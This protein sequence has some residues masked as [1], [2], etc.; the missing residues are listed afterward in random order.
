[1]DLMQVMGMDFQSVVDWLVAH[2][3]M[4]DAD[5]YDY[6]E[7]EDDATIW[8]GGYYSDYAP[9]IEFESGIAVRFYRGEAWD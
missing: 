1:M 3:W 4:R 5:D 6:E 9:I 7:D 2:K 8:V